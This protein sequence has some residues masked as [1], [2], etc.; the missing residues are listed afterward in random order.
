MSEEKDQK[1]Y[2]EVLA[3]AKAKKEELAEAKKDLRAWKKE[4][5]IK[6][7]KPVEDE[8]LKKALEKKETQLEKLT[9]EHEKA[10]K[11]AKD[12]K[13]A[14]SRRTKYEYPADC[15]TDQD[16]KKYRAKMRRE[17]A[18][19]EKGEN[20]EKPAK[21]EKKAKVEKPSKKKKKLDDDED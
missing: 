2:D 19:A 13:P 7:N 11:A 21:K 10:L 12:L 5:K 15:V 14:S 16:K 8:K 9:S 18:K 1:A 20:P 6:R 17:K 4:N 3:K